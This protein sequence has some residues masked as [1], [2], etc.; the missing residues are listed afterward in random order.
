MRPTAWLAGHLFYNIRQNAILVESVAPLVEYVFSMGWAERFF[1]VRYMEHGPHFRLRFCGE[2]AILE[3]R[4]KPFL[5]HHLN[6]Y[7]GRRPSQRPEEG[8][9]GDRAS[10]WY[11]NNT[12]RFLPYEPEVK[13]YGGPHGMAVA[14]KVFHH[15]S[16]AVLRLLA[17]CPDW[18]YERALGAA[19]QL[20]L[21]QAYAL[22]FTLQEL[23]AFAGFIAKG[24]LSSSFEAVD[25]GKDDPKRKE[26]KVMRAFAEAF[27]Q[28][29]EGLL[30]FIR[31]LW[32]ALENKAEFGDV[33]FM[34]WLEATRETSRSL[35]GLYRDRR[36]QLPWV[37]PQSGSRHNRFEPLWPIL[38]AYIHMT[39]NRLGI[40]N[41]D[42]SFLGY[43]L[44][45]TLSQL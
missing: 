25:H 43:L 6:A 33:W 23:Q 26:E 15:S 21:G 29:K 37:T 7:L 5:I 16:R 2:P 24:W 3:S 12:L 18:D 10:T 14:E 40:L 34:K 19:I 38:G 39:N 4:L 20:H 31:S 44:G 1:F 11:P 41:R 36:L 45:Q 17:E 27:E 8:L 42:E 35:N 28:Q 22:D 30:A 13:R 32:Q 9:M